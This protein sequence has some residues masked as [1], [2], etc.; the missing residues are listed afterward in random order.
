MMLEYS[1]D[2]IDE[3]KMVEY[4]V[5]KVLENWVKTKNLSKSN[6]YFTCSE[7]AKLIAGNIY[8]KKVTETAFVLVIFSV[9][10]YLKIY[11]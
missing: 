5:N 11:G 4:S 8:R 6:K 9:L 2:L 1:F 3:A 7:I 10:M